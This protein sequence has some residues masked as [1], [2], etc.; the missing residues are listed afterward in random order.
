[1]IIKQKHL[2]RYISYQQGWFIINW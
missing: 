2:I 1:M